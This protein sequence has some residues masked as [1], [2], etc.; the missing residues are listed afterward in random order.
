MQRSKFLTLVLSISLTLPSLREDADA[1]R[2]VKEQ[3]C[4]LWGDLEEQKS[5]LARATTPKANNSS[6]M[7]PRSSHPQSRRPGEQPP[8]DSDDED[9]NQRRQ[10]KTQSKSINASVL[11]KR[12]SNAGTKGQASA[13]AKQQS[14]AE[15][16]IKN[17]AFTCCIKQYGVQIDEKHP[18]FANAGN[19]KRWERRFGL[20][21]TEIL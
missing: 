21:G 4:I 5:A 18:S 1:L 19:G 8:V 15:L 16:Q 17:K 20:F 7:E 10:T 13:D 12:D 14:S 2:D 3:L 6:S 9:K 11:S